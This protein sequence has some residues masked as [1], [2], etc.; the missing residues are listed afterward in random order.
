M[1]FA[2]GSLF[3][4]RLFQARI[5]LGS[6]GIAMVLPHI[7]IGKPTAHRGIMSAISIMPAV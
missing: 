3:V 4:S 1:V 6:N 5:G 7:E 2:S